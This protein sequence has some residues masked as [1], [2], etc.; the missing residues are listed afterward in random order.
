MLIA[1]LC[2]L[3]I[4][5]G[6]A[7]G[8]PPGDVLPYRLAF[9]KPVYASGVETA[10]HVWIQGGRLRVRITSDGASHRV[11]GELRTSHDGV[12]EDV[13][14]VSENLLVRQLRPGRIRFEIRGEFLEDGFDVTLGGSFNQVT[15]DL[16]IDGAQRADLLRIGE[17]RAVPSALPARLE[18][19]NPDSTWVERFGF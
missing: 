6:R 3:V 1:L 4:C 11:T 5:P 18:L 16:L 8:Q 9:G 12:L 14:P 7:A 2:A 13:M 10:C 15:I 17:A 19:R